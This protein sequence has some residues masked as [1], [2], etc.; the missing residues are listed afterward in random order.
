MRLR[1]KKA[2][3]SSWIQASIGVAVLLGSALGAIL[4]SYLTQAQLE[5]WGWRVPFLIGTLIGPV[6]FYIRS[7]VD[8]T[9][10]YKAA[11]PVESPL[12]EVIKTYPRQTLISFSLVVLWTVCTYAILFCIPSYAQRVLGL[13]SW[14][15]FSAGMMGG[16]VLIVATPIVGALAD[17]SGHR[18]WLLGSAIAIFFSAYPMFLFINQMPGLFSLLVF[19]LVLGLLISGYIGSILAAFG[20]LLPTHVLSTGLSVAYNFAVTIFGGFATFTIT[21]LIASTG[22]NLAPAFYIIVRGRRQR[23]WCAAVSRPCACC[24]SSPVWSFPMSIADPTRLILRNGR[25]L[26]LQKGQLISGQE[27]V[28]EGERIIDVRAEGEPAPVGARIIDLGGRT[29]MPGLIDCHVHVLASNANLGMNALQPN[30]IIMYRALPILAAMLNRG[31]TTVRDA[32]GADWALARSIQMGLIPGPRIFA[33][34]KALSQTGGHGDMRARGELLLNEPCSCC[35]RAGAIAGVVDGVD[36]VRLAVREELQQ[37]ANQI[38]I[39]ASGGVSSPTDPIANTQYSEAEIRAIVDEAAAANTYVMAHAY[40]ARAIRRAIECGV[41]TIEHGNL[42]DAD[43]ARLMAEKGAFAV[44]TQVTYE[45]LAE[46]GE[47]FGLPADSVAKIEDVRQAGRNALL[48]FAE[49]GVPMGYGSD[50]LGEMHE[51][52]THELKIRAELLGNLAAL[53]SA[54]SVAAQILQREGE[55]GCISAGAIADLLVVDGDPLSDIGCLVGQGEHLAM[56]VQGGHVR[57]NTLV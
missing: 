44:P 48:L 23:H 33:S 43:T 12:R 34:G 3:Y 6:G 17:R 20:E 54:T 10:A 35:F 24:P 29:L 46:Y 39:M 1:A 42:V 57:K 40:T 2:F 27:V 51:Y 32:G 50:L 4:S 47:R 38:K 16:A 25:L 21:W 56:I 13:P 53:R 26:D 36:N 11:K 45:M 55:L 37:G 28:I 52:Q 15:G 18:P 22:S 49:A 30:A 41:R 8:E 19:E 31:F 9:P 14:M 7:R 5:S